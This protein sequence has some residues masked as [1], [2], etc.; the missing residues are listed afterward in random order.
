[1]KHTVFVRDI[2]DEMMTE[3]IDFCYTN[4]LHL[5]KYE[6]VDVSDANLRYDTLAS[7]DFTDENDVI[8]FKLRFNTR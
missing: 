3:M 8:I 4:K 6:N 1:M 7:F 5:E 2:T